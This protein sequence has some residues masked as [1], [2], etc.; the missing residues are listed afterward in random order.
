M[1]FPNH[2]TK[3]CVRYNYIPHK[4]PTNT[5]LLRWCIAYDDYL[6]NMY[7]IFIETFNETYDHDIN[8]TY[9]EF[10]KFIYNSSSKFIIK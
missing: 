1:I 5:N 8:F 10:C 3:K 4:T 6:I 7:S 9:P 2:I